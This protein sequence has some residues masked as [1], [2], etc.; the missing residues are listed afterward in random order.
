MDAG[1]LDV[2]DTAIE[3]MPFFG[4]KFRREFVALK[5]EA[6]PAYLAD[7]IGE[8]EEAARLYNLSEPWPASPKA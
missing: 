7:A 5:D 8:A 4:E 6:A 1:A 3:L 2:Q